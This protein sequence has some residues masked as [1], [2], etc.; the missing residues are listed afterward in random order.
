MVVEVVQHL[1]VVGAGGVTAVDEL[2]QQG[3]VALGLEVAVDEV[4]PALTVGVAHLA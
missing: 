4:V 2:D 1:D 3:V